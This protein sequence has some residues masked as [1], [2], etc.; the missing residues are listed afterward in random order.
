MNTKEFV[1]NELKEKLKMGRNILYIEAL[2]NK[3]LP[4]KDVKKLNADEDFQNFIKS[5]ITLQERY[6]SWY[7]SVLPAIR[8]TA[9][10]R[11]NDFIS[12]YKIDKR[13]TDDINYLNYCISDY[14]IGLSITRGYMEEEVVNGFTAFAS[15]FQNQLAILASCIEHI[16]NILSDIEGVL[17]SELFQN[18]LEVSKDLLKKNHLRAS[19]AIAGVTLE[20]HLGKVCKNHLLKFSKKNPTIADFND[21][22]KNNGVIDT[23]TWR[24]IQRLGDIRNL[25]VHSK[26]REPTKSEVDDLIIGT[27]K[28]IA[29]LY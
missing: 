23:P 29:E 5:Y 19:G 4:D 1:K 27:E 8:I 3:K 7:T 14:L 13:K 9:P 6:N 21:E 17:Q 18:E 12:Y 2:L 28:L 24:L 25:C 16:D 15:K 11:F 22:L 26:D 20:A 10:D